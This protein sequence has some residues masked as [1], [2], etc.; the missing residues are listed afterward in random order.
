M[1]KDTP[2]TF[3]GATAF[4]VKGMC[5]AQCQR[6]VT[7]EISQIAGVQAVAVDLT[8]GSVKVTVAQPVDRA[9][10]AAAVVRRG[11]IFIPDASSWPWRAAGLST[12]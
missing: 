9:E 10:I 4:C 3:V 6:A 12:S 7:T 8:T 2:R 11:F 5:C 1:M